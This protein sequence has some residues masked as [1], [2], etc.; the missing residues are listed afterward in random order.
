MSLCQSR[1]G[2]IVMA[3]AKGT[4]TA[5]EPDATP[6][7]HRVRRRWP[8]RVAFGVVVLILLTPLGF[9][10]GLPRAI[11]YA[12]NQGREFN[13]KSDPAVAELAALG[14]SR[15]LRIPVGPPDTTL[16]VWIIEPRS[17]VTSP[18]SSDE[19]VSRGTIIVLHGIRDTKRTMLGWG[20]ML[21]KSG[22]RAVLVDLRGHGRSPG[23]WITF[24]VREARD[25]SQ[26]LDALDERG[27][28]TAPVGVYGTSY[29]GA[30][31][32]Q[33]A[34][35]D[36]R[37]QAVVAVAPFQSLRAVVPSYVR[38]FVPLGS[39]VPDAWIYNAIDRAGKLA[40]F[41]PDSASPLEAIQRISAPVLLIHGRADRRIPYQHS[42]ALH[43]AAPER[44]RLIIIDGATH[45]SITSDHE[46]TIK[47]EML[48]WFQGRLAADK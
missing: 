47:R 16:S 23:E 17:S 44:T 36:P 33:F 8:R 37:V 35:S 1:N 39:C 12:P 19:P 26:L 6:R 21:A 42:E 25:L 10:F 46:R 3:A 18:T 29:G 11:V 30:V 48:L 15:Q 40:S 5:T 13:D 31:G 43:A 32:I 28:L 4:H 20:K 14:V 24:G 41:D 22:Y 27:L 34:A 2:P 9:Y 7:R 45:L 38:Y